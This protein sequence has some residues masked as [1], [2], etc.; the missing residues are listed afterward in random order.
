NFSLSS[1]RIRGGGTLDERAS[2]H[3]TDFAALPLSLIAAVAAG[4]AT[5]RARG[6]AIH[7]RG[8]LR[9]PEVT[10]SYTARDIRARIPQAQYLPPTTISGTASLKGQAALFDARVAA[11]TG[12]T[13]SLKGTATLPSGNAALQAKVAVIGGI[14]MALV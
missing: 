12:G 3:A 6:A 2:D 13:L 10:A 5:S 9:A 14:D 1:G 4:A 11:G 7:V 8:P